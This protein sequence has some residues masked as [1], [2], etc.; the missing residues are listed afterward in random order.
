MIPGTLSGAVTGLYHRNRYEG[1][2][3]QGD[4]KKY[5]RTAET[6]CHLRLLLRINR[7]DQTILT[8]RS[9]MECVGNKIIRFQRTAENQQR[10]LF[11]NI[12][13]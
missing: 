8:G 2:L 4:A 1:N 10:V 7:C 9:M 13:L 5:S 6:I 11:K 3:L 12:L